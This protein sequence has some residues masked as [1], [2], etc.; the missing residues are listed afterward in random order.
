MIATVAA[1]QVQVLRRQRVV[2]GAVTLML[3]MTVVAGVLGWSSHH[4]VLGVYDQAAVLLAERGDP[5]PPNPIALRSTLALLANMEV[6]VPLVGALLALLVG[7][8][9]AVDDVASGIGR[10]VFSRPIDRRSY[11]AGKIAAA[12]GVLLA[13]MA[14]GGVI[15]VA[16][17]AVVN[18]AWP[19]TGEVARI[20]AFYLVSWLYLMVFS[21]VGLVTVLAVGRRPIALLSGI[22]VWLAITF[23]LP[24]LTSGQRPTAALNPVVDGSTSSQRFFQMT[25]RLRP[26]SLVEQ[27]KTASAQLL[28]IGSPAQTTRTFVH[29]IPIAVAVVLV[30]AAAFT[31]ISRNDASKG[32]ISD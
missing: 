2:V 6:Y 10:L 24:Q 20:T 27:Y 32:T 8:L 29:V 14:A 4:T 26:I 7:H 12:G 30:A 23:L 25:S 16:S 21:I 18:G 9:S 1:H 5:V 28:E 3:V 19:S 15:G 31:A 17:V 13:L 11:L 22:G